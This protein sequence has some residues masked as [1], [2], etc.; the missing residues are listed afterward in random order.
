MKKESAAKQIKAAVNSMLDAVKSK[1]DNS[2]INKAN[3]LVSNDYFTAYVRLTSRPIN[4]TPVNTL[5]LASITVSGKF[6]GK[7]CFRNAILPA[8][9]EASRR[10]EVTLFVENVQDPRFQEFF[11]KRGYSKLV[12]MDE[13]HPGFPVSFHRKF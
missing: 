4:R 8:F 3:H 9:E 1:A 11:L 13:P 5:E 12:E 10:L 7:G 2:R 6:T